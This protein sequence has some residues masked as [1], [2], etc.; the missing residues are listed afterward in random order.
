MRLRPLVIIT[1]HL[2]DE[3]T[4]WLE[5]RAE[6]V[7]CAVTDEDFKALAP[8]V[9]ALIVR[10]YTEVDAALLSNLPQLRA[11]GRAGVGLDNVDERACA[12]RGVRVFNTP[13][14]N[15]QAVVEYVLALLCDALR[16]RLFLDAPVAKEEWNEIR[17]EVVGLWQMNELVLGILGFGRVG[18]RVTEVARA[19]GFQVIY[20]DLLEVPECER[21][22][23]QPVALEALFTD[24]D[25]VSIHI[26]GRNENRKFVCAALIDLLRS[27]AVLINTARGMVLDDT[28]LAGF[29]ARNPAAMALLDVHDPEPFT[30]SNPLL[31]LPN[32]HLA[33]HLASRT[34]SAMDAMSW[35]VKDVWSAIAE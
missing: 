6:V 13:D 11:V 22:G 2:S 1:E 23:A 18:K 7:H 26:D 21:R 14:A 34:M 28:A 9:A 5:E 24:A 31:G 29:L 20:N 16:P 10:T 33:P 12:S 35:V 3:A 15:T 30:A 4:A 17:Q 19:I 32:A 8:R 27:D 25:I